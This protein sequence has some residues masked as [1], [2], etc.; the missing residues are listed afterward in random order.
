MSINASFRELTAEEEERLK[1]EPQSVLAMIGLP[2]PAVRELLEKAKSS[3]LAEAAKANPQAAE[4]F[5]RGLLKQMAPNRPALQKLIKD[6]KGVEALMKQVG[7]LAPEL[8]SDPHK[9]LDFAFPAG[10]P[11]T[12]LL[13]KAWHGVHWLVNGTA[14]GGDPPLGEL[15]AGGT[16]IGPDLGYGPATILS[17]EKVAVLS[18]ALDALPVTLVKSRFNLEEALDESVYA[19]QENADSEWLA[20]AYAEL[21]A[22][23][24]FAARNHRAVLRWLS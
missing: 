17:A 1:R 16:S 11:E 15:I 20:E 3:G 19:V 22:L 4:S 7:Q 2:D 5:L 12:L 9:L 24:D 23:Y 18:K 13:R 8:A 10:E 14:Q 21:S 6:G